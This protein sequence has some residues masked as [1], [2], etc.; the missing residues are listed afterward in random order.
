MAKR[1]TRDSIMAKDLAEMQWLKGKNECVKCR[2]Q[3]FLPGDFENEVL[4][5]RVC[6]CIYVWN[7]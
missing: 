1:M 3:R 6:H 7:M 2:W 5:L 4:V